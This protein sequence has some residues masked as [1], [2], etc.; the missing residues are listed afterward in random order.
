MRGR[1]A[2]LGQQHVDFF[3]PF[4]DSI[5][6]KI[7]HFKINSLCRVERVYF[8]APAFTDFYQGPI[9]YNTFWDEITGCLLWGSKR[10][11]RRPPRGERGEPKGMTGLQHLYLYGHGMGAEGVASLAPVIGALTGLQRLVLGD[12]GLGLG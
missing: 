2:R 10:I 7:Q 9:G 1:T 6:I 11:Q 8:P 12:N 3:F 4:A 5:Q